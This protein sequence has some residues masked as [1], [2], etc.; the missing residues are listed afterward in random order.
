MSANN[1][2]SQDTFFAEI[3]VTGGCGFVLGDQNSTLFNWVEPL[4]GLY[5]KY[6]FNGFYELKLQLDGG[7]LGINNIDNQR[8]RI[9]YFST[10]LLGEFNFFNYGVKH[11]E[12]YDSWASPAIVAGVGVIGFEGGAS[13][14]IPFGVGGKFKLNNRTN[15]GCYWMMNK[16]FNDSLDYSKDPYGLNASIF[17]NR[18]WYSTLQVFVSINFYK[19]CAPCR[20]RKKIVHII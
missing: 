16:L 17:S 20:N 6:K 18:D 9:N 7:V 10:Q 5:G 8:L 13:F 11:W 2:C 4:G 12:A 3:G 1:L 14:F 19:I 15:V